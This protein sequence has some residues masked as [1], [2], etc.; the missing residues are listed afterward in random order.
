MKRKYGDMTLA[1]V[2]YSNGEDLYELVSD[3]GL[4]YCKYLES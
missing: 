4:N 1:H 3:G 2:L